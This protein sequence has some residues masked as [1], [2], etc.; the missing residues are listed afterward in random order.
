MR[1]PSPTTPGHA[2]LLLT[3]SQLDALF[4]PPDA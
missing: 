2:A 3:L 4:A 1:W